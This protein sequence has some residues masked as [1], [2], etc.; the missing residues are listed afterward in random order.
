MEEIVALIAR[1]AFYYMVVVLIFR[2]MGKREIGELSILD[3]VVYIM[4]AEMAVLTIDDLDMFFGYGLVPMAVLLVIQRL[5]AWFSLKSPL[6]RKWF[7]GKPSIIISQGKIDEYEMK[8]NRFNFD[9]LLQQLRENGTQSI[10]DVSYAILEPSGNLSIIEKGDQEP[11]RNKIDGLV[12]PLIIDGRIQADALKQ[13]GQNEA[14]LLEQ[15]QEQ[16]H[17]SIEN[18]SFCSIDVNDEWYIDIKNEK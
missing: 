16:N 14:W 4:I 7:E 12:L 9:D 18:I 11:I 15:L 2:L 8:K 6:F 13:L 5:T 17:R 10:K 3:I 1:T